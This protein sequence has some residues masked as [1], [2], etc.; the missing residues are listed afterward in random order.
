MQLLAG[1][2]DILILTAPDAPGFPNDDR[3]RFRVRIRSL[4]LRQAYA[5]YAVF[6]FPRVRDAHNHS[7]CF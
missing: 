2:T 7:L 5:H 6:D 3:V 4:T 1:F